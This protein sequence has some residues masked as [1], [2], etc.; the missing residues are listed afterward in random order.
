MG[1]SE[2]MAL[3]GLLF[4]IL[5]LL[6]IRWKQYVAAVLALIQ[7]GVCVFNAILWIGKPGW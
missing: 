6:A 3:A 5:A 7:C 2:F 1:F 4:A